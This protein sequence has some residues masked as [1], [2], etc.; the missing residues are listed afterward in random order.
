MAFRNVPYSAVDDPAM[1]QH[2]SQ[3]CM[4]F[5]QT[6]FH[7]SAILFKKMSRFTAFPRNIVNF[8]V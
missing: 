2:R 3:I 4:Q 5:L 1:N 7:T 8:A 6:N